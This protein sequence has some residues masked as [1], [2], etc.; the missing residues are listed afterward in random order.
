MKLMQELCSLQIFRNRPY[1]FLIPPICRLIPVYQGNFS[2][3]KLS[4]AKFSNMMNKRLWRQCG[5]R[6]Y[7]KRG[8]YR[9]AT[10]LTLKICFLQTSQ[11]LCQV[12]IMAGG[13]TMIFNMVRINNRL[14]L[15]RHI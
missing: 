5:E 13:A 14:N 4:A 6:V 1:L 9:Q 15:N 11:E 7:W 12:R 10:D 2:K 3:E 8:H